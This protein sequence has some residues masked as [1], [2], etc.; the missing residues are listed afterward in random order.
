MNIEFRAGDLVRIWIDDEEV[1][2]RAFAASVPEEAGEAG[3]GW[4]D[5][6]T[7]WPPIVGPDDKPLAERRMGIVKWGPQD[8]LYQPAF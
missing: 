4:A 6:Y 5:L 7:D 8:E 1:T 3:P 2:W